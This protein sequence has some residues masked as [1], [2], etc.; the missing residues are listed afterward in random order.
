VRTTY[1]RSQ[2]LR[3]KLA[4]WNR[5][6][7]SGLTCVR[8]S[9]FL[10][11]ILAAT[12]SL[13]IGCEKTEATDVSGSA[14]AQAQY[15]VKAEDVDLEAVVTLIEREDVRDAESV[16]ALLNAEDSPIQLD[17]D[18][19]G[20]RDFISVHE[21]I[22]ARTTPSNTE[23]TVAAGATVDVA[24][25]DGATARFELRVVPSSTNT[26]PADV[27]VV[28]E[29][30]TEAPSVVVATLDFKVDV[31]AEAVIVEASY[32]PIVV[33]V[34]GSEI[35]RVYVHEIHIQEHHDH[36]IV[37]AAPFVAWVWLGARPIYVGHHHLPPG[38]AKKLG[39]YWHG[40]YGHHGYGGHGGHGN[41]HVKIKSKGGPSGGGNTQ[42]KIKSKGG[43]SGGGNTQVKVKSK[44]GGGGGGGGKGK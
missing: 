31:K 9:D 25:D 11:P 42:V 15:T 30:E 18:A 37:I 32:A 21:V 22:E 4:A 43:P 17:V 14:A 35:E 5:C 19:D 39:L 1:Y 27:E 41:T 23:A 36:H 29:H 38:H 10:I 26:K 24:V 8:P 33:I 7:V 2:S 16:E 40:D 34:E 13:A 3:A 20:E 44:G 6:T 28:V 12:A